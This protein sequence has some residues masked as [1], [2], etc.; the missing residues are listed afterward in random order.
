MPS[1]DAVR[2]ARGEHA[3]AFAGV[4]RHRLLAEHVLAGVSRGD[5]LFRMEPDRR[6]DV[7]ASDVRVGERSCQPRIPSAARRRPCAN[8]SA[9]SAS[10]PA[11]GDEIASRRIAQRRARRASRTMSPAPMSPHLSA[12]TREDQHGKPTTAPPQPR[13]VL[14]IVHQSAGRTGSVR[15][16]ESRRQ[17]A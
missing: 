1:C 11:D 14:A 12:F 5:R 10:G 13:D 16:G 2:A 9:S 3:I 17:D 4:H 8:A 15:P 7:D 6:R